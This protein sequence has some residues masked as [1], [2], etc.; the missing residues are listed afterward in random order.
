MPILKETYRAEFNGCKRPK[1][2]KLK[3]QEQ[4]INDTHV[5]GVL[6]AAPMSQ[7]P[8]VTICEQLNDLRVDDHFNHVY[9]YVFQSL[10]SDT[11]SVEIPNPQEEI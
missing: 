9:T 7:V 8:P 1:Y 3:E 11:M 10:N 6:T 5:M 2:I 4:W